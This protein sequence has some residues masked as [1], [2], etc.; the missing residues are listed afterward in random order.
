M[1]VKSQNPPKNQGPRRNLPHSSISSDVSALTMSL[2]RR[3][4]RVLRP[5][6]EDDFEVFLQMAVEQ[7]GEMPITFGK[8]HMGQTYAEVWN[9]ERSWVRWF[10]NT[11][12]NSEKVERKKFLEY[13]NRMVS[14][15]ELELGLSEQDPT[16]QSVVRPKAKAKPKAKSAAV[17]EVPVAMPE[18]EIEWDLMSVNIQQQENIEALQNRML[19]LENAMGEILNH[20]R[21]SNPNVN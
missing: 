21:Q 14:R 1:T 7:M 4:Q 16:E 18:D 20:V 3:L 13:V 8:A 19:Y 5:T 9:N 10:V 2:S 11:Y 15:Q 12:E 6:N 17:P